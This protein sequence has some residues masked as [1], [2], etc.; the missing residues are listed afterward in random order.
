MHMAARG[1]L[2]DSEATKTALLDAARELFAAHGIEGASLRAIQRQAGLAAGTLQYHFSSRQELLDALL[3]RERADI[4]GKISRLADE[5]AARESAPT[6]SEIIGAIA[7]PYVEFVRADPVGGPRYMKVLAQVISNNDSEVL[8][9][10]NETREPVWRLMTRAY[11][12]AT[13]VQAAAAMAVAARA[14]LFLLAGLAIDAGEPGRG[15]ANA[16]QVDAIILFAAGGL[17]ALLKRSGDAI[18]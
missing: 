2:A 6:A 4:G 13:P 12:D 11:P 5:L 1:S 18:T 17:D 15:D 16:G 7:M 10:T 9:S 14:L 8:P 3:A